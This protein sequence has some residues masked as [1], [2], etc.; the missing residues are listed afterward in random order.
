MD[1]AAVRGVETPHGA[2]HLRMAG[3]ADQHHVTGVARITRHFQMHLGDQRTGGIEHGE[4]APLCLHL[5][6]IGHAMRG[7]DHRGPVG[8]LVQFLDKTRAQR[9]QALDHV[10]VVHHL[11]A[12]VDGCPE[13]LDGAL[14]DVDGAIH[15]GA[16]AAR[17]GQQ[18]LHALAHCTRPF[19][20]WR[21]CCHWRS[22][23]SRIRPAP[24]VMQLSATLKA[25]K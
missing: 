7:E 13:Q 4:P 10:A 3:V 11:V 23:S 6:G 20:T 19:A 16:E 24:T 17:I 21:S 12:N 9:A 2:L 18:D 25:G 22:A 1:G 14:D 15:A 8:H 5:H